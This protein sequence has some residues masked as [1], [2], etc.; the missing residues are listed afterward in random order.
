MARPPLPNS[1]WIE[2]GRLLAGE[3]PS[4]SSSTATRRRLARLLD[5]GVDCFIDLTRPAEFESYEAELAK[6]A[7]GRE[8]LYLR[9]PIPDHG[10][11]ESA[12]AMR[13]ILAALDRALAEGRTVYL[14]CRAGIG[15]T[16]LVAGCWIADQ[17]GGGEA[18][19]ERLN[20]HWSDNAR[21]RTWP[22][23]PE[24]PAQTEFVRGWPPAPVAAAATPPAP[25]E[26]APAPAVQGFRDRVRGMMLGLAAGDALGHALHGLPAGAW[27]DKA[28]MALCLAESLVMRRGH[29][30]ADQVERY[31]EWQRGGLWSSTGRCV[32]ISAATSRALAAAQWNGIPYSGSHDPAHA[33]AEPLARIGPV[34]AWFHG[35]VAQA[36]EGAVNCARITHQAPFTLEAARFLAALLAGALAGAPKEALLA[37][38]YSPDPAAWHPDTLRSPVREL[39]AGAWRGRRPRKLPRGKLAA[40]IALES[41]LAAFAEGEDLAQCLAIAADKPGDAQSAAAIA[42]Q[43]AGAHYGAAALPADIRATLARAAE[44]EALADALAD[45]APRAGGA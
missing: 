11:P 20:R 15:R 24:T 17:C 30:A 41:A 38:D 29:D 25:V 31:C 28:A 39:A 18:A 22:T 8:A 10:V 6:A 45:A 34:V 2:S 36:I 26:A 13:E 21:S 32:G 42:G 37:E 40:A 16:N 43:L 27:S 23:I 4:G 9:H 33:S 35:D 19:L 3:H 12:A 1:H 5:A 7:K 44:I 14:H